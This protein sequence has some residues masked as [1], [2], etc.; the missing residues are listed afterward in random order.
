MQNPPPA[1]LE[2]FKKTQKY[3]F[4]GSY[5]NAYSGALGIWK[6]SPNFTA[7]RLLLGSCALKLRDTADALVHFQAVL[8]DV[9]DNYDAN[10]GLSRIYTEQGDFD[11]AEKYQLVAVN[12]KPNYPPGL[13]SL[14]QLYIAK[15]EFG[16]AI[17]TLS[18]C[19]ELAPTNGLTYHSFAIALE[20]LGDDDH[21]V[22]SYQKAIDHLKPNYPTKVSLGHVYQR[23]G[24]LGLAKSC[25]KEAADQAEGS[26]DHLHKLGQAFLEIAQTDLA[27][28]SFEKARKLN[29]N[30]PLLLSDLGA[31]YLKSGELAK[32]EQT[33]KLVIAIY[34]KSPSAYFELSFGRKNRQD[35]S[36]ID[37]IEL[38]LEDSNWNIYDYSR[39]H[40]AAGKVYDDTKDY[41]KAAPHF[42]EANRLQKQLLGNRIINRETLSRTFDKLQKQFTKPVIEEFQKSASRSELP[43]LIIG[44]IRSGTTLTEQ[45]MSSH[46]DV[47]A[48]GELQFLQRRA[49]SIYDESGKLIPAKVRRVG[50]DYE[51][52]LRQIGPFAKRVT[53]KMPL[54]YMHLGLFASVFPNAKVIHCKRNPKDIWVSMFNTPYEMPVN[55][56]HDW[57]NIKA[58]YAEYERIMEYWQA[59][60]PS[61]MIIEVQYEEM[62]DDRESVVRRVIDFCGL[63]WDDSVLHHEKQGR[64]ILTPSTWQARQPLYKTSV[65]RWRNYEIFYPL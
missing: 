1:I 15:N 2:R 43:L 53:D 9:P 56:A 59:V 5:K 46:P 61:E 57:E 47:A 34:P 12:A 7:V 31:T 19:I 16:E 45:I 39:L 40:Y 27:I 22:E 8:Q 42:V 63:N 35:N 28:Q 36:E 55:F 51:K 26:F 20:N 38:L 37:A 6:D 52:Y 62:L 30:N 50:N 10:N 23:M 41:A 58:F 18:R 3:F 33:L 13:L 24:N 21:A 54:N 65:E 32:A 14:G 4:E 60:L 48:A 25:W 44:M 29:P 64:A 49:I 11:A 17:K